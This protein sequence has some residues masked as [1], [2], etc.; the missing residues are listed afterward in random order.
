MADLFKHGRST[1]PTL[2][3]VFSPPEAYRGETCLIVG[4]AA[5]AAFLEE[6]MLQFTGQTASSR[7]HDGTLRGLVF[8]DPRQDPGL[9]MRVPGLVRVAPQARAWGTRKGLLH[10]KLLWLVFRHTTTDQPL[11]RVV[12]STGNWTKSGAERLVD[13]VWLT[14]C[15]PQQT[16][17]AQ[18]MRQEA[19]DC[20]AAA[21]FLREVAHYF[22]VAKVP[23]Y[24][25][26]LEQSLRP[27]EAVTDVPLPPSRL[28]DSLNASL[29]QQIK[30]RLQ[31]RRLNFVLAGSGFFE[32]PTLAKDGTPNEPEVLS[33]LAGLIS[34][35]RTHRHVVVNPRCAGAVADWH[36]ATRPDTRSW[37]V[38]ASASPLEK[39]ARNLHAKF[40][41]FA[42]VTGKAPLR[43]GATYANSLLYLG[44]G[45]LSRQGFLSSW[46]DVEG[47]IELGV[48]IDLPADLSTDRIRGALPIGDEIDAVTVLE[49]GD[50]ESEPQVI[51]TPP[52][53]VA[54]IGDREGRWYP[55]W[56]EEPVLVRLRL[57]E[58]EYSVGPTELF[59]DDP[60]L[61]AVTSA[62]VQTGST[63]SEPWVGIPVIDSTGGVCRQ[64]FTTMPFDELLLS[65]SDWK[66]IFEDGEANADIDE[67]GSNG[68]P[69][70]KG[71]G[72]DAGRDQFPIS[73]AAMLVE[74]IAQV[75]DALAPHEV[76]AWLRRL[77]ALLTEAVDV[78]LLSAWR[79][80]QLDL[81]ASLTEPA[82]CP[83]CLVDPQ[84]TQLQALRDDYLNLLT[85]VR[86]RWQ[87]VQEA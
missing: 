13:L 45:N 87:M 14:E 22:F 59:V 50:D 82:F 19:A 16:A 46:R 34:S 54:V 81:L 21:T 38:H 57:G 8:L 39:D 18:V 49:T 64:P 85:R 66:N 74:Q 41:L 11:L 7:A 35:S 28:I 47:N 69:T 32:R 77:E 40:A 72:D 78:A 84:T 3:D 30:D 25:A 58:R 70:P 80:L 17:Q 75:H 52:P 68:G 43:R 65:L 37:T 31:R 9:T 61:G 86:T 63:P 36:A 67:D 1:R 62:A 15:C 2:L 56:A 12:V 73:R 55:Q 27:L 5:D 33:F 42:N 51:P 24:Q 23:P 79:T 76:P 83:A 4:F 10:A 44:S 20:Q 6:A 53:V 26:L 71:R 60:A 29:G 48:L